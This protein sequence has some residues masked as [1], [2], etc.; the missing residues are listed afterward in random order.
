MPKIERTCETCHEIFLT[1]PSNIKYHGARFCSKA[2]KDIFNRGEQSYNYKEKPRLLCKNCGV[3]FYTENWR[4][5]DKTTV[6]GQYCSVKCRNDHMVGD[7][8]SNWREGLYAKSRVIR[9]SK[10]YR[11]W[12]KAVLE[13]DK[14]SCIQCGSKSELHVDHIKP[15][16]TYPDLRCEVSNGRVL[17]KTCHE[18]TDSYKKGIPKTAYE[19]V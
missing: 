1:W 10:E 18:L 8:A 12:H 19:N 15:F 2:C 3:P 16:A 11:K 5:N 17:C 4:L 9:S 14:Y 13:R 6:R 7:E